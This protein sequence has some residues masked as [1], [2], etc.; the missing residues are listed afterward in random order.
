MESKIAQVSGGYLH[1]LVQMAKFNATAKP[2]YLALLGVPPTHPITQQLTADAMRD[3]VVT[4]TACFG[5]CAEFSTQLDQL[6]A[7]VKQATGAVAAAVASSAEANARHVAAVAEVTAA[8]ARQVAAVA[9]AAAANAR[10]AAVIKEVGDLRHTVVNLRD[11]ML[12][13]AIACDYQERVIIATL[14]ERGNP[15]EAAVALANREGLRTFMSVE[16]GQDRTLHEDV[17]KVE[18]DIIAQVRYGKE[19]GHLTKE[20]REAVETAQDVQRAWITSCHSDALEV[21]HPWVHLLDC[22]KLAPI[23]GRAS[24]STTARM[25]LDTYERARLLQPLVQFNGAK[26]PKNW[27]TDDEAEFER[28]YFLSPTIAASGGDDMD[29]GGSSGAAAGGSGGAGAIDSREAAG[30]A[31]ASDRGGK[32]QR[33][34]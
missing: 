15:R 21:A 26:R 2:G 10:H 9:D 17:S 7:L 30:G 29:A 11:A 19:F 22:A 27:S 14:R 24:D 32:R 13:R 5:A 8:N 16:K 3:H 1:P 4:A 6:T 20:E 25:M 23:A 33:L 31:G 18:R 34:E 12:W 28:L